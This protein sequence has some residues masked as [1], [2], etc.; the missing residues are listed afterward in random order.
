M[1][2]IYRNPV[3][4]KTKHPGPLLRLCWNATEP[5]YMAVVPTDGPRVLVLDKRMPH[6]PVISV[7][8]GGDSGQD[9]CINGAAWSPEAPRHLCTIGDNRQA[10]I[11]DLSEQIGTK[12]AQACGP[13]RPH[14]ASC[15][16]ADSQSPDAPAARVQ[17]RR[18][19]L[20]ASTPLA[21]HPS[22]SSTLLS[23]MFDQETDYTD[24]A[25][26]YKADGKVNA[27]QWPTAYP[28]W[29]AIAYERSVQLLHV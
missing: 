23:P 16:C 2:Y 4:P 14:R 29:I 10:L 19:G 18:R 21:T 22:R 24:H 28:D 5:N 15:W 9:E 12:R 20:A 26:A 6:K 17:T 8:H 11:W 13:H 1:N 3:N 25:L 27:L 7:L